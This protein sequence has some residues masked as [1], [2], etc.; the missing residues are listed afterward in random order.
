MVAAAAVVPVVGAAQP[1]PS[2]RPAITIRSDRELGPFDPDRFCN[3]NL[4]GGYG[5]IADF[6]VDAAFEWIRAT[7]AVSSIRCPM[8]LGEGRLKRRPDWLC[9]AQVEIGPTGEAKWDRL[10]RA[11]DSLVAAGVKP[12]ICCG[13]LPNELLTAPVKRDSRGV[14]LNL[15]ANLDRYRKFL[16]QLFRRLQKTYG[17]DEVRSW[18]FEAWS[19]PDAPNSPAAD[20]ATFQ[21]LYDHFAS[22]ADE[23][24]SQLQI[25]A[26]GLRDDLGFLSSFLEHCATGKNAATGKLGARITF[27]SWTAPPSNS[28]LRTRAEQVRALMVRHKALLKTESI[29][30]DE[31]AGPAETGLDERN[32]VVNWLERVAMLSDPALGVS[33]AVRDAD[34]MSSHFEGNHAV[35]TRVGQ[36]AVPMAQFR[37]QVLLQNLGRARVPAAAPDGLLVLATRTLD[38]RKNPAVQVLVARTGP[39]GG[40]DL[41]F[42]V[43]VEAL[44]ARYFRMPARIYRLGVSGDPR[45]EWEKAGRPRPAPD[46]LGK[47]LAD[48][49][50]WKPSSENPA[51]PVNAGTAVIPIRLVPGE[52]ALVQLG[53]ATRPERE[54][55]PRGERLRAAEQAF[56]RA[57]ALSGRDLDRALEALDRLIREQRDNHWADVA[58]QARISFLRDL[59]R[60]PEGSNTEL[61]ALLARPL[62][63]M[64]RLRVLESLRVAAVRKSDGAGARALTVQIVD[65]ERHLAQLAEWV[66]DH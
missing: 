21:A 63:R 18:R 16:V 25:G 49:A 31:A 35:T 52:A 5:Q 19:R 20:P 39:S 10:E 23:V 58:R 66:D 51:V 4:D 22:A 43:R 59:R 29:V 45:R 17:E 3:L 50:G 1:A 15:P 38:D 6:G 13:G 42:D 40:D 30:S 34:L 65:L 60:D 7:G 24:D 48:E 2:P 41:E 47:R 53:S 61:R 46:E 12:F 26:P 57:L 27:V 62:D 32:R 14:P 56:G 33:M 11:L 55:S 36:F 9:G 37:A 54:I 28:E 8:W 64:E 44:P